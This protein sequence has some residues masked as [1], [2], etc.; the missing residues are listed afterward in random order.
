[1]MGHIINTSINVTVVKSIDDPIDVP[2]LTYLLFDPSRG[3]AG[4]GPNDHNMV[5]LVQ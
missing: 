4:R 3:F 2:P 5:A 1:M